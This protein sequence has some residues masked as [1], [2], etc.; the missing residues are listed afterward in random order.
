[1]R[2]L[3]GFIWASV[4][5]MMWSAAGAQMSIVIDNQAIPTEDI[6]S[7]VILPNS[8]II[9]VTT[10]VPYVV[11]AA[12]VTGSSVSISSFTLSPDTI[13]AGGSTTVS[14][15]AEGATSCTPSGGTGGWN[16]LNLSVPSGSAVI[17]TS[18]LGVHTFILTCEDSV[19]GNTDV[20]NYAL[21]V[22]APGDVGITSFTA[23]PATIVEGGST[24]ISWNT[25]NASSCTASGG[26]GGWNTTNISVPSGS[27][28]I[29]ASLI[30]SYVFT[31]TCQDSSG[32]QAV[33][34]TSLTV[35]S[36]T[37]S[38]GPVTL[39]GTEQAWKDFW[40]YSFP[41]PSYSSRYMTVPLSGYTA[42]KFNTGNIVDEG[43][44]TTIETTITDGVR[45]G[46]F[47]ECPGDFDVPDKCKYVWGVGGGIQWATNGRADACQLKPYTDYYFNVTFTNGVDG[48]TSSC[49][50]S[51]CVTTLQYYQ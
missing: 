9:S 11:S 19:T 49:R 26:T 3:K 21:T 33:S 40:S 42:L 22:N 48:N 20:R 29:T 39:S 18:V 41:K 10:A 46:S 38:C 4:L 25:Q 28:A 13:L 24:I 47:S 36:S 44:I 7:I 14:W 17:T 12:T 43:K 31:L 15:T 6:A 2:N 37:S 30:G 1:M 16:T 23:S 34:N 5:V 51:P 27:R 35:S 8:N 32:G 50:S 45:L